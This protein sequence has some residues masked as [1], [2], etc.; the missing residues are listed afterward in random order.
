MGPAVAW[1]ASNL[2]AAPNLDAALLVAKT[3]T[4]VKIPRAKER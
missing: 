2:H 1:A 4:L 3:A